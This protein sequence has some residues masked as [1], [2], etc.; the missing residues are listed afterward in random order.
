MN[1][2]NAFEDLLTFD[3]HTTILKFYLHIS[4]EQQLLELQER[5]DDPAKLWKHN[6]GDWEE[7][8]H[9][10]D[11]MRC[12]EYVFEHSKIPWTVVPVD[13]R[14]YRDYLIAKKVCETLE[15][16]DLEYPFKPLK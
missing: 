8:G 4:K 9:W 12:Y 1:A 6:D 10:E 5:K 3:N 2:I 16:L 11:Y 13:A 14:W 7:R 15:S